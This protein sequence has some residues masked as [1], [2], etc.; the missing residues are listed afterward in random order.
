MN[1]QALVTIIEMHKKSLEVC[2]HLIQENRLETAK[3]ILSNAEIQINNLVDHDGK[4]GL[5]NWCP[6]C[7]NKLKDKKRSTRWT[8]D[9]KYHKEYFM[10]Q[11]GDV[12]LYATSPRFKEITLK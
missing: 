10:M 11:T 8:H 4:H 9:I 3:A 12:L 2:K 1:D 6:L 7:S 5:L